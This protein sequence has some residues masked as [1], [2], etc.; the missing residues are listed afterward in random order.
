MP[1]DLSSPLSIPSWKD[2]L[3]NRPKTSSSRIVKHILHHHPISEQ[4]KNNRSWGN[5]MN[6][7]YSIT[8]LFLPLF[9]PLQHQAKH[10][11]ISP[12]PLTPL[13]PSINPQ[14]L[15]P[16]PIIQTATLSPFAAN[17]TP[18]PQ[19][20][21]LSLPHNPTLSHSQLSRTKPVN[22]SQNSKRVS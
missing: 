14:P 20:G 10:P 2:K 5:P 19:I 17:P 22:P 21:P 6:A 13:Q 3:E 9:F 4:K 8:H 12:A 11:S 15:S 18:T 16:Q 1:S 7:F